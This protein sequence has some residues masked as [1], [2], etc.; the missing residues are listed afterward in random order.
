M[1]QQ[2]FESRLKQGVEAARSGDKPRARILLQQILAEDPANE[3]ALMWMASVVDSLD[4]RK[5]Y[6]QRAIALNPRNE[7]AR[8]ALRRLGVEVADAPPLPTAAG[9]VNDANTPR[10]GEQNIRDYVPN[11]KP[12]RKT[13][14]G[15]NVWFVSALL[16]GA[17]LA[18]VLLAALAQ[19]AAF[20]LDSTRITQT[21][22]AVADAT[23]SGL[24]TQTGAPTQPPTTPTPTEFFGILVGE[25]E[26]TAPTLPPTFTPVPSSTPLPTSTPTA[27][28]PPLSSYRVVYTER[29]T[30]QLEPSLFAGLGDGSQVERLAQNVGDVALSPSGGMIAYARV[31]SDFLAFDA[32]DAPPAEGTAEADAPTPEPTAVPSA[33]PSQIFVAPLDALDRFVQLTNLPGEGAAQPAWSPDGETIAFVNR[34]P[35]RSD[36]FTVRASLDGAQEPVLLLRNDA[37][38]ITP[39]YLPDGS[40]LLFASDVDGPGETEIYRYDFETGLTTRL[41]DAGGNSLSPVMSPDGQQIAFVSDRAG[42]GDIYV[43]RADGTSAALITQDDGN[44]EDR[45]PTWSP[46]GRYLVFASN[47][48]DARAFQWVFVDMQGDT[49]TYP[50]LPFTSLGGEADRF[51]FQP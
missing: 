4:D 40:G 26:R 36:L 50:R 3:I 5:F 30:G 27:T 45:A 44:A 21:A 2:S 19:Q 43:M 12:D 15:P 49:I 47:G 1:A 8:E 29:S 48:N 17:L 23:N 38:N 39:S 35:D 11:L 14:R 24:L 20:D 31:P 46:D 33:P 7:R 37:R 6:L 10:R 22:A 16:V 34:F 18:I 9:A 51:A 13:Q 32:A 41:T 25:D 42:D 28:P